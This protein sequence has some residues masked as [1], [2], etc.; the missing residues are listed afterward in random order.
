MRSIAATA[1]TIALFLCLI[2]FSVD[3]LCLLHETYTIRAQELEKE[4]WLLSQCKDPEFFSNMGHH[5]NLCSEVESKARIGAA[6]YALNKVSCSLQV[7]AMWDM[8]AKV[9][10][11][12]L[13]AVA[14]TFVLFPSA[15]VACTRAHASPYTYRDYDSEVQCKLV[16]HPLRYQSMI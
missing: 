13:A 3:K 4:L 16:P 10:W 8:V 15:I 5:T 11:P 9:S 12:I 7:E 14:A 2:F 1:S 6:W